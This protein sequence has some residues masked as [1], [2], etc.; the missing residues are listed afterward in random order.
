MLL[1]KWNKCIVI[2]LNIW[3]LHLTCI[4]SIATNSHYI[5]QCQKTGINLC[6]K[7]T[8]SR[9]IEPNLISSSTLKLFFWEWTRRR[10]L[11]RKRVSPPRGASDLARFTWTRPCLVFQRN[12]LYVSRPARTQ[13]QTYGKRL[14]FKALLKTCTRVRQLIGHTFGISPH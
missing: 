2:C 7:L 11:W 8:T 5:R 1:P 14:D 9:R 13:T 6:F 3:T 12:H 10:L 4:L